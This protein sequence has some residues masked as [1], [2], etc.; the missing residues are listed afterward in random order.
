MAGQ[1]D[2][3]IRGASTEQLRVMMQASTNDLRNVILFPG[4]GHLI[5]QERSDE[6]NA[7]MSNFST[8]T[9]AVRL[10][11][12]VLRP[13]MRAAY[14]EI[15]KSTIGDQVGALATLR[16]KL[17]DIEEASRLVFFHEVAEPDQLLAAALAHARCT[18]PD[19]NA[20][21]ALQDGVLRQSDECTV[22]LDALLPQGM[23][24]PGNRRA[25]DCRRQEIMKKP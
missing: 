9:V 3:V 22:A 12:K 23:G 21:K 17:Y 7:A 10:T 18:T 2:L 24:D 13:P 11:R 20:K 8:N 14:V 15:I 16:G 4:A 6:V 19:C 1:E 5:Q 25:H